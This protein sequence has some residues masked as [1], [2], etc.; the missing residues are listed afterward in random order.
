MSWKYRLCMCLFIAVIYSLW[1]WSGQHCKIV[2]HSHVQCKPSH[3]QDIHF[4]YKEANKLYFYTLDGNFLEVLRSIKRIDQKI[5]HIRYEQVKSVEAI[6]ELLHTVIE[7]K[8]AVTQLRPDA[9]LMQLASAKL[10]LAI[11]TLEHPEKPMWLQYY[12]VLVEDLAIIVRGGTQ[13]QL[14]TMIDNME[15][16]EQHYSMIRPAM[17]M[18]RQPEH[19]QQIDAWLKYLKRITSKMPVNLTELNRVS[20]EGTI[21]MKQVF[22]RDKDVSGWKISTKKEVDIYTTVCMACVL[23]A[24]LSYVSYRKYKG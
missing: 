23:F 8:Q 16:L 12:D 2:A 20:D 22:E 11:D 1:T 24:A 19:V 3:K 4:L 18:T 5:Q 17:A 7:V 6:H 9:Q 13:G 15:R 10:R 14:S 21:L